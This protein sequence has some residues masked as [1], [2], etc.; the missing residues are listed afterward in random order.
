MK[1]AEIIKK[2]N[3]ILDSFVVGTNCVGLK[4]ITLTAGGKCYLSRNI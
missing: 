4:A 1:A 2:N 3:I